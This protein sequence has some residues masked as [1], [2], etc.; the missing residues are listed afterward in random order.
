MH[1]ILFF[2]T[3]FF[4]FGLLVLFEELSL[5]PLCY[6]KAR[7]DVARFAAL[8]AVPCVCDHSV[9]IVFINARRLCEYKRCVLLCVYYN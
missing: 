6:L 1:L 7:S 2:C 5:F 3:P 4:G 8:E 9:G